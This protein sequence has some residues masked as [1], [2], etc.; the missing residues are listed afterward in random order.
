M[1]TYDVLI[2]GGG[3]AGST[4]ATRLRQL[5]RTVVLLDRERHPKFHIGESLLPFT[6][7][8]LRK[9]GFL[10]TLESAGFVRKW[11]SR[12]MTGDGAIGHTFYFQD[13][14]LDGAPGAWQVLRSRFDHL[15]F[16]HAGAQGAELRENHTLKDIRFENDHVSAT[17]SDPQGAPF[18]IRAR[19]FIDAT[20][21]DA[22]L[23]TRAKERTMDPALRKVAVFAHY[24]GA[25]RDEGRDAGNTI[26]VVL[27]N[28]W[29]WVIPLD[30]DITS[31][32]I[33]VDGEAYREAAMP[34]EAFL[35]AVLDEVPTLRTRLEQGRRTSIVRV[36]S[37]FSYS[38][39]RLHGPRFLVLGDAGFFLDPIFS[40]GVHLAVTSGIAGAEAIHAALNG[41]R[42]PNPFTA[43]EKA[44]RQ[45]QATYYKFIH[46]WYTPGFLELF[47]RPSRNF[48]LLE[49][50]TSV[51]AGA[52]TTWRL[53]A[54]VKLFF[55]LV[56]L[57]RHVVSLEPAIDRRQLP[58]RL[59]QPVL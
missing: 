58:P 5:G 55:F 12:F 30:N 52:T 39:A 9:I 27:R 34:P 49:A 46:G 47:L 19:F 23:A 17:V 15:L 36:T 57:N 29:I 11:G 48:H 38:T 40:S 28:G 51:L 2:A 4:A 56:W 31:V 54:R 20:G 35:D 42:W 7:P 18:E 8:L 59:G 26:S 6:M 41:Q 25:F 21:R 44:M 22:F 16:Q 50:I 43:Y 3:P 33:V 24:T 1:T 13:G 14:L 45:A 10:D 32:G 37:D 53:R